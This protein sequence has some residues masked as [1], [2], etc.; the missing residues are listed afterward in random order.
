MS[1]DFPSSTLPQV[2]KRSRSFS[3]SRRRNWS[4]PLNASVG[5][6]TLEVPFPLLDLHRTFLVEVDDA[7]LALG[8]TEQHHLLDDFRQRVGIGADG[9]GAGAASKG[10]HPPIPLF[11]ALA[12]HYRNS[13]LEGNQRRSAPP[14]L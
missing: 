10:A 14:H 5:C 12:G 11:L 7:I 9:A 6:G 3:S 4:I 13:F 2:R 8:A 1:V